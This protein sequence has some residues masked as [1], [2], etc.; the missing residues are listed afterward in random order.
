MTEPKMLDD[1][2]MFQAQYDFLRWNREQ[3]EPLVKIAYEYGVFQKAVALY[4]AAIRSAALRNNVQG[5][6][7]GD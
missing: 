5:D 2:A 1:A 7:R 3:P 6:E 4:L